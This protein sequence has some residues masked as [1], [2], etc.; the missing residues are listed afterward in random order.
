MSDIDDASFSDQLPKISEYFACISESDS[1]LN[2][3][4]LSESN[5][6]IADHI[7]YLVILIMCIII[8]FIL[9]K[10]FIC[11]VNQNQVIIHNIMQKNIFQILESIANSNPDYP[12]LVV[13]KGDNV[14]SI[15]YEDYY[16]NVKQFAESLN[17]WVGDK[18]IVM[19]V[20]SNCPAYFYAYLGSMANSG[21]VI[22]VDKNID[23][24]TMLS[25]IH[26]TDTEVLVIEDEEQLE[27]IATDVDNLNYVKNLKLIL[28]YSPI[29]EN[30][31]NKFTEKIPVVSYGAFIENET[32]SIPKSKKFK[33][34]IKTMNNDNDDNIAIIAYN[35]SDSNTNIDI[36]KGVVITHKNIKTAIDS[37]V[38]TYMNRLNNKNGIGNRFISYLPLY[39]VFTQITD[40]FL[41]L[42]F[43]GT[44][45]FSENRKNSL[46]T[47][48]N[49]AKPTFFIG[50]AAIWNK[51]MN[52]LKKTNDDISD[53]KYLLNVVPK[54]IKKKILNKI[55]LYD[56]EYCIN[57][58]TNND[59]DNDNDTKTVQYFSSIGLPIYNVFSL[60][61]GTGIVTMSLSN[62]RRL[63]SVGIPIDGLRLKINMNGEIL[64][65]GDSVFN[66]Y[67]K[68]K[69]GTSNAFNKGW[70]KT[71]KQGKLDAGYLFVCF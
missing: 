37:F 44:V 68:N 58:D 54:F 31:L 11:P 8:C 53:N 19:I 42:I 41:P 51:L 57:I 40:I 16:N 22:N 20:G 52:Y 26:K 10:F 17:Y 71:G 48:L 32:N 3:E 21:A 23:S 5:I 34:L 7:E 64:I 30:L 29:S 47:T 6:N 62:Y 69:K 27:K 50:N 14:I 1:K 59:N 70:F 39:N 45:W 65:K 60:N 55:G 4:I 2:S 67:Y 18:S 35:C 13:R 38:K 56:A 9:Y 36:N 12:A 61:E 46:I 66:Q 33:K 49:I 63:N 25:I 15:N 28:Y 24:Q 43:N